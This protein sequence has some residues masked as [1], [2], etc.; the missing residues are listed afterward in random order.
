MWCVA[1]GQE[2]KM[3]GHDAIGVEQ[4][5]MASG[6]GHQVTQCQVAKRGI[7]EAGFP[8]IRTYGHEIDYITEVIPRSEADTFAVEWHG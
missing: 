3:I 5:T 2:M 6:E 7:G 1:F 4:E 8:V